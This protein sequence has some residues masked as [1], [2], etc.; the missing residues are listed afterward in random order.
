[1]KVMKPAHSRVKLI[2]QVTRINI[3]HLMQWGPPPHSFFFPTMPGR[4]Y[5][6]D[7]TLS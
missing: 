5:R 2:C 6:D 7:A 4:N 3:L 1:M